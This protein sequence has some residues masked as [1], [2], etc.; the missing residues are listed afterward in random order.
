MAAT[1]EMSDPRELFLHAF[2][3]SVDLREVTPFTERVL[4]ELARVP[5]GQT[6]RSRRRSSGR[7]APTGVSSTASTCVRGCS[8]S[9][10]VSRPTRTGARDRRARCPSSRTRTPARPTKT[11]VS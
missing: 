2:D 9:P 10:R 5:F 4:L 3:L 11:S 1:K 7:F 8:R 6:T